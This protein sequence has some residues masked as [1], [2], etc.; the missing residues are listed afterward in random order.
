MI[1][2][3]MMSRLIEL[4][5]KCIYIKDNVCSDY[6]NKFEDKI[7]ELRENTIR[8]PILNVDS[9]HQNVDNLHQL[10]T[11]NILND[12]ILMSVK[13]YMIEYGYFPGRVGSAFI[14]NM[15]FNTSKKG[16]F[17]FPHVHYGSFLSGAFYVKT[18]KENV[19]LFHD[20]EK[21]F[22][23]DPVRPTRYNQTIQAFPCVASRL[24]IF[25]SDFSSLNT[26]TKRRWGKNSD[27]FQ[28]TIRK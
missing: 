25:S 3:I 2:K 19:I 14:E 4:F 10:E 18:Q 12:Q 28:C 7:N 11:F 24:I 21:H 6:L 15:W 13:E 17:L 20:E 23:E 9:S 5:P 22:Y 8:S 1:R 26:T 27:I 16:D